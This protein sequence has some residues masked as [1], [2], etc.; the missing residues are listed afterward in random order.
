MTRKSRK[1][2]QPKTAFQTTVL[3]TADILAN[4]RVLVSSLV[5]DCRDNDLTPYDML[6]ILYSASALASGV[7]AVEVVHVAHEMSRA[8]VAENRGRVEGC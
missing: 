2:K 6:S 1:K 8:V 5:A 3:S 4:A 7:F